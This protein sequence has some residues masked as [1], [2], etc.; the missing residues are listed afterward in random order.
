V[1]G[2]HKQVARHQRFAKQQ[3]VVTTD[4]VDQ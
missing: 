4:L 3:S 1:A 2:N